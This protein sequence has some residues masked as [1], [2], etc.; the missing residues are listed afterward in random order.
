MIRIPDEVCDGMVEHVREAAPEEA[1]GILGGE[2]DEDRSVVSTQYPAENVAQSPK[3]EYRIDPEAQYELFERIEARDESIVGFYHSHP[4]GPAVPSETDRERAAWPKH[5]YVIVVPGT[6]PSIDSWR[7]DDS[8]G[9][10]VDERVER[11]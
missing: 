2:F 8:E 7:F 11:V 3:T 10:F 4:S 5:S 9:R 6:D 1:C